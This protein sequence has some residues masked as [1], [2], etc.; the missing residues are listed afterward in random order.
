M[1]ASVWYPPAAW[2]PGEIVVTET[3]PQLLPDAFHLGL[4]VGPPESL[5]QPAARLP[6][7]SSDESL[8]LQ[9]G[10]WVQLASFT[11]QGPFLTRH[12][13]RL[14]LAP[15][16]PT[17]IQFE[18]GVRLS[19]YWLETNQPRPGAPLTV[20]LEWQTVEP[21][22]T[23]LTVFVH[24]VDAEGRLVAQSDAYP[25]WLTPQP[26]SSWPVEQ[27]LLDR[28]TLS[29]PA[30]LPPGRYTLRLGL[31]QAQSLVRLPLAAGG[32]SVELTTLWIN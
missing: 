4:A 24:L 18:A 6:V 9:P 2:Q 14:S 3:L 1:V 25:T 23:D 13:P 28:H 12:A 26:T 29:L 21:L 8:R 22:A 10:Q 5:A 31:Y 7:T 11:H 20:L 19:G 15:L 17:Q 27:P 16:T 32:D 30:E